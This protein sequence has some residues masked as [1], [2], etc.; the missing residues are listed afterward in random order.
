MKTRFLILIVMWLSFM[1]YADGPPPATPVVIDN[2]STNAVLINLTDYFGNTSEITIPPGQSF[3]EIVT[4]GTFTHVSGWTASTPDNGEQMTV[5]IAGPE[6]HFAVTLTPYPFGQPASADVIQYWIWGIC[7]A[8]ILGLAG[9]MR[10]MLGR[11]HEV[12]TDL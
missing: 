1:A 6:I 2:F 3:K 12:N 11:V 4:G 10:R 8:L 7:T 5:L 9:A